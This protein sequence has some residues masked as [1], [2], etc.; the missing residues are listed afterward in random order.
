MAKFSQRSNPDAWPSAGYYLVRFIE[1]LTSIGIIGTLAYFIYALLKAKFGVPYEFIIL[2]IA[3]I[4]SLFNIVTS[5]VAKC[6]GALNPKLALPFDVLVLAGYA[7]AF[8]LLNRAMD[9]L[10]FRSCTTG[11]WGAI[12]GN[13]VYVCRLYKA[14]WAFTI[15]ALA[16]YL[17]SVLIDVI[18]IRRVGSHKYARANPKSMEQ[19]KQYPVNY[20]QDTSYG[21]GGLP[22]H[23]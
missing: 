8:G 16:M 12:N 13:G 2:I 19:T 5:G 7:V 21:S 22:S 18:V 11:S 3:A 6:C 1:F 14:V 23:G 20:S 15:T 9:G 10:V 17:F 4:F